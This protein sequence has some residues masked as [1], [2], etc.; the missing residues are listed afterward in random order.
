MTTRKIHLGIAVLITSSLLVSATF[1]APDIH[2]DDHRIQDRH[3]ETERHGDRD[4]SMR[5]ERNEV[6]DHR[7]YRDQERIYKER[8]YRYDTRYH[9]NRYYPPR[10]YILKTLPRNY[11]VIPYRGSNY[12]YYSGIWY[13]RAGVSFS[14]VFPPVGIV[15]PVLPPYYTTVWVGTT[16]YYYADGVYYVWRPTTS[17]Y[18]VVEAPGDSDVVVEPAVSQELYVY[19]K[20]GQNAEQTAKDRYECYR[21]AVDQAGF[22]PTQPGG[23]VSEGQHEGKLGDYRRAVTACLEGRGYSVK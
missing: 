6:R 12:Y 15:V 20:E 1:A 9:H 3:F 10:G 11:R 16:P 13:R 4:G 17:A 7:D 21:W 14:V 5:T 22:D 8:G 23:N 18:E 19:P 2:N